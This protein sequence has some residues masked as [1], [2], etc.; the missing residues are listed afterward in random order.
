MR[1]NVAALILT[2]GLMD[3]IPAAP[4]AAQT[5]LRAYVGG[6]LGGLSV[7][8]DAVDDSSI[9]VGFNGGF[10][11]SH[12]VDVE[13]DVVLPSQTLTRSYSGPSVS[14]AA[15]G[16]PVAERDRLS[17]ITRFDTARDINTSI[18][19]VV[20]FHPRRGRVTPGVIIGVVNQRVRDTRTYTPVSIPEGVDPSHPAVA[21]RSESASRN[22]GGPT[23]GAQLA[24][25]VSR[26]LEVVPDI[27]YD[28]ASIGDE[29][30]NTLRSSVRIR[31]W[32]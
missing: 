28:Y 26:R 18:S 30:N 19:G 2:V 22:I 8:A 12:F 4:A 9:A 10:A 25:A 13:L 15:P 24:V 20:V 1:T 17:V 5:T 23:F 29:I 3:A 16:A 31:W 27:R 32:F 11:L 6:S 14:F 21:A 7:S